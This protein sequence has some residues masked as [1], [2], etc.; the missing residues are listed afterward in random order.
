MTSKQSQGKPATAPAQ[1]RS[2]QCFVEL[3]DGPRDGDHVE[4]GQPLPETLVVSSRIG[5]V[6]YSRKGGTSQYVYADDHR[7]QQREQ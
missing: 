6:D 1:R 4:Y 5:W 2:R 7:V 3:Q